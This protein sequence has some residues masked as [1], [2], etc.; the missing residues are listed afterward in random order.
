M[1]RQETEPSLWQ[2]R[3]DL[4]STR[5]LVWLVHPTED[6]VLRPEVH[7]FL[8]DR[9]GRLARQHAR[10]GHT[11]RASEL[12]QKAESHFRLGGGIEPPPAVSMAMALPRPRV[13]V[14]AVARIRPHPDDA[15]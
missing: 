9:Y 4:V 14:D 1:R 10:L 13:L 3:W 12:D 2:L 8:A 5:V 15:A 7:L 11:R 6:R